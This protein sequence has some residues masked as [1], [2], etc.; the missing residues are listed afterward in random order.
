MGDDIIF[1]TVPSNDDR[2]YHISSEK[3][4]KDLQFSPKRKIK[5]AVMDLK[6]AFEAKILKNTFENEYY[7]NIHR[8]KNINL[9]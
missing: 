7:F 6:I 4:L 1:E 3:I 8:M 2:S 9:I 5:D